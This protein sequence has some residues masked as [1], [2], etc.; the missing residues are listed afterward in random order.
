MVAEIK[1]KFKP[2]ITP[3]IYAHRHTQLG[4]DFTLKLMLLC[5]NE[6]GIDVAFNIIYLNS[7]PYVAFVRMCLKVST[8][9]NPFW[10]G[11]V[12]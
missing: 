3:N 2:R 8:Q 10:I 6:W 11:G 4:S 1:K 9:I 12:Y 7:F 5:M